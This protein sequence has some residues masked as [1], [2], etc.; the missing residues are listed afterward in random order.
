M[1]PVY[2]IV[3]V[4]NSAIAS[5]LVDVILITIAVTIHASIMMFDRLWFVVGS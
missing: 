4:S 2:N 3:I 5:C 1:L